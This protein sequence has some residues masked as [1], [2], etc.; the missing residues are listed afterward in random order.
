MIGSMIGP[1]YI[2]EIDGLVIPAPSPHDRGRRDH[3]EAVRRF[4]GRPWLAVHWR[5]CHAYSRIYRNRAASA[6]SGTCPGCGRPATVH[7]GSDGT[8][9][10]FFQAG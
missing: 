5:C 2:V 1:D 10:R 6:Y 9:S 7:I 3:A 8:S 4:R